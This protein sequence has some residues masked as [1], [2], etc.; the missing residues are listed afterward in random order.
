MAATAGLQQ[1]GPNGPK[2]PRARVPGTGCKA[3]LWLRVWMKIRLLIYT[4]VD[5]N[6]ISRQLNRI[7]VCDW[8]EDGSDRQLRRLGSSVAIC[9]HQPSYVEKCRELLGYFQWCQNQLFS[10][11]I[12]FSL[13]KLAPAQTKIWAKANTKIGL[14][15][16]TSTHH[17][18]CKLL[19]Q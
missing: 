8:S 13:A 15:T 9:A 17:H 12:L 19:M 4:L 11:K 1:A 6:S 16:T 5:Q 18:H 2:G 10:F 3:V 14:H 7:L